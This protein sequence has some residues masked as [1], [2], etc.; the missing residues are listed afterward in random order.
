MVAFI[1]SL[2]SFELLSTVKVVSSSL[3]LASSSDDKGEALVIAP[4]GGDFP[5]LEGNWLLIDGKLYII[6]SAS[7]SSSTARLTLKDPIHVFDR[8]AV[9]SD[10]DTSSV[11][12]FV[13]SAAEKNFINCEDETYALPYISV[14]SLDTTPIELSNIGEDGLYSLAVTMLNVRNQGIRFAWFP[15]RGSLLLQILPPEPVTRTVLFNTGHAQLAS[16][17]Y[18]RNQVSKVTVLKDTEEPEVYARTDYYL[19][20]DG[21]MYLE[22]PEQRAEGR[23]E[24]VTAKLKDDPADKALGVFAGNINSHKIEFYI[25]EELPLGA[26]VRTRLNGREYQSTVTYI[27]QRSSDKRYFVKLGELATTVTDK[28]RTASSTAAAAAAAAAATECPFPVGYVWISASQIDPAVWYKGTKWERMPGRFLLFAG[29]CGAN[30][31]TDFG[32]CAKGDF[33]RPA[34]ELGGSARKT[35]KTANLPAHI[36]K[37]LKSAIYAIFNVNGGSYSSGTTVAGY[38]STGTDSTESA[39][40]GEAFD[41]IAP[42]VSVYGWR[43]TA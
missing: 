34:G 21:E 18:S 33:A 28:V 17:S 22:E 15:G 43:R 4:G 39:G 10:E 40:S 20:A 3:V 27:Q 13:K 19:G 31:T 41:I 35:L 12:A 37:Y 11:G 25:D 26:S 23:W 6:D 42:Y 5:V 16:E 2:K 14:F 7:P 30:T 8:L 29:D 24:Y 32:R 38:S 9:L 1:L 36:H